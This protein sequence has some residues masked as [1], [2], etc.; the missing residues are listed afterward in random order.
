MPKPAR[1]AGRVKFVFW[2]RTGKFE[3]T[4]GFNERIGSCDCASNKA[5]VMIADVRCQLD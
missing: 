1:A 4:I 3:R 2:M 5:L